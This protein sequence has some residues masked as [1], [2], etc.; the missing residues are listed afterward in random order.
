[1]FWFSQPFLKDYHLK[2]K[3]ADFCK[4]CICP[5]LF[6]QAQTRFVH[7][8]VEFL[9]FYGLFVW[10][11]VLDCFWDGVNCCKTM[12]P[13]QSFSH[14]VIF[15]TSPYMTHL[16][17]HPHRWKPS[18]WR[19]QLFPRV[20][21]CQW[22]RAALSQYQ[23]AVS[24]RSVTEAQRLHQTPLK[25]EPG[26]RELEANPPSNIR[27]DQESSASSVTPEE[28]AQGKHT[29]MLHCQEA[30]SVKTGRWSQGLRSSLNHGSHKQC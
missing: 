2:P 6:F 3:K 17:C 8:A 14:L 26:S 25:T 20:H 15:R 28:S 29:E 7:V 12:E 10:G 13:S 1:M 18:L 27:E 9:C 16:Q 11:N 22:V 4:L 19:G 21:L 5:E 24:H 30:R 23:Q